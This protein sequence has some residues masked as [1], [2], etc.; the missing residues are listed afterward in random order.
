MVILTGGSFLYVLEIEYSRAFLSN[1]LSGINICWMS[2][3][4]ELL[5]MKV[6]CPMYSVR[7][8]VRE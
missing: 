7:V 5:Y 8:D 4:K 3:N 2:S 1:V 6:S